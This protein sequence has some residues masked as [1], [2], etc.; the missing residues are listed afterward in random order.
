MEN[1][2]LPQAP[3]KKTIDLAQLQIDA[4]RA[5]LHLQNICAMYADVAQAM[6]NTLAEKAEN[7]DVSTKSAP[8]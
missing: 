6:K 8:V 4:S 1:E 5:I 2:T 7:A 3:E